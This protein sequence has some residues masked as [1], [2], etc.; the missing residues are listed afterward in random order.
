MPVSDTTLTFFLTILTLIGAGVGAMFRELRS[1]H[2]TS[3]DLLTKRVEK[4]DADIKDCNTHIAT[5]QGERNALLIQ[6]GELRI[7]LTEKER[8]LEELRSH[9]EAR[10][11]RIT[12]LEQQVKQLRGERED[13]Q[14]GSQ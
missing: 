4:L 6:I 8:E 13:R 7:A 10:E 5:L 2:K 11:I 3:V 12:M 9:L 14:L 1:E